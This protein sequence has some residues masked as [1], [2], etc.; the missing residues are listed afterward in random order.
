MAASERG[1]E[2]RL[3]YFAHSFGLRGWR[4][5]SSD[6][7]RMSKSRIFLAMGTDTWRLRRNSACPSCRSPRLFPEWHVRLSPDCLLESNEVGSLIAGH[8][9]NEAWRCYEGCF[10]HGCVSGGI[11]SRRGPDSARTISFCA[12]ACL[13]TSWMPVAR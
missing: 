12:K 5:G 10:C 7:D 3:A 11:C 1:R 13:A 9:V 6:Q 2:N 8:R 4:R